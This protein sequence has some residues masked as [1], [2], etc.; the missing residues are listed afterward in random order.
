MKISGHGKGAGYTEPAPGSALPPFKSSHAWN[1][2]QLDYGYW[3]LIDSCWG[4]G[5]T[6]NNSTVYHKDFKP[7]NFTESN[8]DFGLRHYPNN[9]D[10]FFRDDGRP[11]ISWEEYI[12]GTPE[13]PVSARRPAIF[14]DASK[15]DLGVRTIQPA[16]R[17]ISVQSAGPIRFQFNLVC[18]HWTYEHHSKAP[19]PVFLLIIGG[20]GKKDYVPF[21]R[22]SPY[23]P[24]GGG[25]TWVVDLPDAR[26]LGNPG[27]KVPLAVLTKFGDRENAR[28]VTVEEYKAMKG[29]VGMAFGFAAQ[30]D[31][32]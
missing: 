4:A 3:K 17:H 9:R 2:V 1:A 24:G 16:S 11:S 8:D 10:H 13:A 5:S 27:D 12:M 32:V 20:E 30:W 25:E 21:E 23:G 7:E 31:L 14:T 28:G 6:S 18:E 19:A 26:M 15:Y 22:Y 29:K